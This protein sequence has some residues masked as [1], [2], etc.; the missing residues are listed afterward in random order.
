[1]FE[2]NSLPWVGRVC[3]SF[4]QHHREMLNLPPKKILRLHMG[5]KKKTNPRLTLKGD[6]KKVLILQSK[7]CILNFSLLNHFSF[8]FKIFFFVEVYIRNTKMIFVSRFLKALFLI[9]R[10]FLIFSFFHFFKLNL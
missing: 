5:K 7:F 10:N 4:G 8:F 6:K 9:Q 1:M 2:S 3:C